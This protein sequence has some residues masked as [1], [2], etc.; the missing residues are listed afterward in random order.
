MKFFPQKY[1]IVIC[2]VI[3]CHH[4]YYAADSDVKINEQQWRFVRSNNVSTVSTVP[5]LYVRLSHK[6][7]IEEIGRANNVN[8]H[9]QLIAKIEGV[10]GR[11]FTTRLHLG[12][13]EYFSNG[14]SRRRSEEAVALNATKLTNYMRPSD[15][16]EKCIKTYSS[17][18]LVH[19][20]AQ[21]YRRR[22]EYITVDEV[23]GNP[24]N[25]VIECHIEPDLFTHAYGHTKKEAKQGAAEKMLPKL[26][27]LNLQDKDIPSVQNAIHMHP[28]S[29]LHEIQSTTTHEE[30]IYE[31]KGVVMGSD[32]FGHRFKDFIIE[33]RVG[34]LLATGS[35]KTIKDAK[36]DASKNMLE[37]LNYNI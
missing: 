11:N 7:V 2:F 32:N 34:N 9:F 30:P 16:T 6:C 3:C 5:D 26:K 17:I 8:V 18:T 14:T 20:W 36:C 4:N 22:I 21:K 10:D 31:L 29:R 12:T 33:V 19:E 24:S 23:A 35:G 25:Y 28:I 37:L 1:W 15:V 13:E 27:S